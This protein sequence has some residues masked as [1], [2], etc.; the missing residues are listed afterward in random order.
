MRLQQA[1]PQNDSTEK[2]FFANLRN[3]EA[4]NLRLDSLFLKGMIRKNSL[5]SETL[6]EIWLKALYA[7]N[8]QPDN[9]YSF[10][11]TEVLELLWNNPTFL[12]Y[13]MIKHGIIEDSL[14]SLPIDWLQEV[15]N[16][17]D[18]YEIGKQEVTASIHIY[19]RDLF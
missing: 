3:H 8:F 15:I 7:E 10:D 18:M 9:A 6:Y 1:K 14:L 2:R 11:V 4:L 12:C 17:Q 19:K 5:Q 13:S 16:K